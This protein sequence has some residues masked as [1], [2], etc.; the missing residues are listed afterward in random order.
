[1]GISISQAY[2]RLRPLL[3]LTEQVTVIPAD[4]KLSLANPAFKLLYFFA[5]EVELVLGDGSCH[6]IRPGDVVIAQPQPKDEGYHY[7]RGTDGGT[8]NPGSLHALII[9][10]DLT[11]SPSDPGGELALWLR[12]T[13]RTHRH[14]PAA[15]TARGGQST[16]LDKTCR[17]C[18][19][20]LTDPY[21][22]WENAIRIRQACASRNRWMR[23]LACELARLMLLRLAVAV[24]QEERP[25]A[26][27][28]QERLE[29]L[30]R[31]MFISNALPRDGG[32]ESLFE[33]HFGFGTSEFLHRLRVNRAKSLL[34]NSSTPIGEIGAQVGFASPGTFSRV[35]RSIAGL[36]PNQYRRGHSANRLFSIKNESPHKLKLPSPGEHPQ[37]W[38][39]QFRSRAATLSGKTPHLV[40]A[41]EGE[42]TVE[43][44]KGETR[45]LRVGE[46][47][48]LLTAKPT[49]IRGRSFRI[50]LLPLT[51]FRGRV[52]LGKAMHPAGWKWLERD[53]AESI[54]PLR[55]ALS[56]K[57][58]G[59]HERLLLHSLT[60]TLVYHS[61][62][63]AEEPLPPGEGPGC[64]S[65]NELLAE[66]AKEYI[67]KYYPRP[68]T[69]GEIA[70]GVGVS[71]EH[72]ARLFRA[73]TGM[74]VMRFLFV[75]RAK[76]AKRLL[77]RT[78]YPIAE[79]A[80][81][82]GFQTLGHFYRTFRSVLGETPGAFRAREK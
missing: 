61:L 51:G 32:D 59:R 66:S 21:P 4:R 70:Y 26:P 27:P 40:I 47:S 52:H 7:R 31:E 33:R 56:H 44:P 37:P 18:Q 73:T 29:A 9:Q 67:S 38:E 71:E 54:G 75:Q 65:R 80:W 20:L 76:E 14:W 34:L 48:L 25:P 77:G 6:A 64:R 35:F 53:L 62:G 50:A 60:S 69:L 81:R 28:G 41:L 1:V 17:A 10:F 39:W 79:I 22:L 49:R 8:R 24:G 16:N 12:E 58:K 57:P 72:L 19:D 13:F 55:N 36:S 74:S 78:R 43:L 15:S 68:L 5:G 23:L 45:T 63:L 11:P 46:N 30:C 2:S 82:C 42:A 3:G